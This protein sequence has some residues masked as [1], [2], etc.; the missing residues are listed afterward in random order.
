MVGHAFQRQF[1]AGCVNTLVAFFFVIALSPYQSANAGFLWTTDWVI[2]SQSDQN[3][4][5]LM[6]LAAPP[7]SNNTKSTD[8]VDISGQAYYWA[9]SVDSAYDAATYAQREFQL[10]GYSAPVR[11]TIQ[12]V[13]ESWAT[14][15][16]WGLRA[17]MVGSSGVLGDMQA[18]QRNMLLPGSNHYKMI[19]TRELVLDNGFYTFAAYVQPTITPNQFVAFTGQGFVQSNM[20]VGITVVPEPSAFVSLGLGLVAGAAYFSRKRLK[21]KWLA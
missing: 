18:Y 16:N 11:V 20:T 7:D 17:S 1:G 12:T 14:L 13:I 9:A 6:K 8:Y 2:S 19:Q 4:V 15:S 3:P 5:G 10:T 21:Q